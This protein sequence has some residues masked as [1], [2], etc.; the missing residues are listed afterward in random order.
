MSCAGQHVTRVVT[1]FC[2][3]KQH[4]AIDRVARIAEYGQRGGAS[5]WNVG[6]PFEEDEQA[7]VVPRYCAMSDAV[8][9]HDLNAAELIVWVVHFPPKHLDK[10]RWHK[11]WIR[12]C[13]LS[14]PAL[15]SSRQ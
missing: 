1:R 2:G 13:M 6:K 7:F 12:R 4:L 11:H 14:Q 9:E 3:A 5:G 15:K 8:V 10:K